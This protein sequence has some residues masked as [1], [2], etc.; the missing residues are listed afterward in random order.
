MDYF[1]LK[2]TFFHLSSAFSFLI[3]LFIFAFS[4]QYSLFIIST[5]IS[6]YTLIS[7]YTYISFY[8]TIGR[9][10][11]KTLNW[12]LVFQ[13]LSQLFIFSLLFFL[14]HSLQPLPSAETLSFL[15][16]LIHLLHCWTA[17]T[18]TISTTDKR[19]LK[20]MAVRA[21][22]VCTTSQCL[23]L[24]LQG[25]RPAVSTHGTSTGATR[26]NWCIMQGTATV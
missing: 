25:V 4:F 12:F 13:S 7:T 15:F 11:Q 6:M 3:P 19:F 8:S 14:S 22:S 16:P 17:L 2:R 18:T 10:E 24:G 9:P 1:Y 20:E 23:A 26:D 21:A 5:Y